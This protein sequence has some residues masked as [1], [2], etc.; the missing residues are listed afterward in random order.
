MGLVVFCELDLFLARNQTKY[1]ILV[2]ED[3]LGQMG[4]SS[5]IPITFFPMGGFLWIII[6]LLYRL[7]FQQYLIQL[8]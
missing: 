2:E 5:K 3:I 4:T 7:R 1:K 8:K 6:M